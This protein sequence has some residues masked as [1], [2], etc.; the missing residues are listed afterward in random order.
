MKTE[1]TTTI[2]VGKEHNGY[3]IC[4]LLRLLELDDTGV[5]EITINA[6][7]VY[8]AMEKVHTGDTIVLIHKVACV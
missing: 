8:L 5:Q 2:K 6:E 7:P 3:D 1:A 4:Y